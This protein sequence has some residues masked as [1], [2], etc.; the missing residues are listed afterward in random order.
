[1][2]TRHIFIEERTRSVVHRAVL[3]KLHNCM[4]GGF[5]VVRFDCM[6]IDYFGLEVARTRR[7]T[8]EFSLEG[9]KTCITRNVST[10][11]HFI[12]NIKI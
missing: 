8:E 5:E 9:N 10:V 11:T 2:L 3:L 4:P 1:M 7:L 6:P 12:S